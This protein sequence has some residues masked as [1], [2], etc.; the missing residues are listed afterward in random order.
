MVFR[1]LFG[2]FFLALVTTKN[3]PK[4]VHLRHGFEPLW[5]LKKKKKKKAKKVASEPRHILLLIH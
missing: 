5:D 4:T 3:G 1:P 2:A